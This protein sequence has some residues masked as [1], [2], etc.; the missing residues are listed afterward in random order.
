MAGS[1]T[2]SCASYWLAESLFSQSDVG[3]TQEG[4]LDVLPLVV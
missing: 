1:S 2:K 4:A 3:F